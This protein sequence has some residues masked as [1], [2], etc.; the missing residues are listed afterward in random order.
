M[1]S[2]TYYAQNYAGIIHW[3]LDIAEASCEKVPHNPSV[4]ASKLAS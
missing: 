3:S 4:L 1:L 2:L